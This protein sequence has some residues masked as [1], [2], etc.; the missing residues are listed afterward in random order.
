[1]K[2]P[3]KRN[4]ICF[5]ERNLGYKDYNILN[6]TEG[7]ALI[8]E[9][10]ISRKPIAIGK[11]GAVENSAL[12]NFQTHRDKKVVWSAS[13]A[14]SLY[15]N[16]GVFPQTEE[17][18]NT[19]CLEFLD[20]LKHFDLLAVW[21]NRGEATIIKNYASQAK[22]TELCALEPYYHQ[23]PWSQYL[24]N[25]KVLVIHPFTESIKQQYQHRSKLW[26]DNRCLPFF[27]LDTIK[28]PLSDVLV[29]SEFEN[30][31]EALQYM[32]QKMSE[33]EFDVAIVGAGSY[34]VPLVAHA[35]KLG[36]FGIHLGGATQVLFGIK[37]KRW[38]NHEI[39]QKFY[40]NSWIRPS[41]SETPE[42][43]SAIEEG[44]YW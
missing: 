37:G 18:F 35:K 31:I 5:L 9:L 13:L 3:F 27:E 15:G 21:F 7:N 14:S 23:E 22:I 34:S 10:L 30:W 24:E 20:S 39:G 28:V 8:S 43:V 6:V 40:N 11:L 42:N 17:I 4:L 38:D 41:K 19:F 25:K 1:M 44:C 29:K 16:A 33:K 26:Q 2:F 12:Q 32:K 36:K